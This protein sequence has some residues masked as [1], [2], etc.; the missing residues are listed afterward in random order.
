MKMSHE[1]TPTGKAL[2]TR[3]AFRLSILSILHE[4][5]STM[6][7]LGIGG[8]G[9]GLTLLR[10]RLTICVRTACRLENVMPQCGQVVGN[11]GT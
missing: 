9:F 3:I 1:G 8:L 10:M 11:R 5:D 6:R 4:D 7:A 2:A